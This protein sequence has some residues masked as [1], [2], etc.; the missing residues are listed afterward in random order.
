M[1]LSEI[2]KIS[3]EEKSLSE[4]AK[5]LDEKARYLAEKRNDIYPLINFIRN[6]DIPNSN[7]PKCNDEANLEIIRIVNS[8]S[9]DIY[10]AVEMKFAANARELR[11]EAKAKNQQIKNFFPESEEQK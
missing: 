6:M 8:L 2:N 3:Q 10:R 11:I 9:Q 4:K 5:I 1:N 7:Y